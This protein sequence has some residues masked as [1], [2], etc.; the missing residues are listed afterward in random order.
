M[1]GPCAVQLEQGLPR[2]S[3]I[4]AM[5]SDGVNDA[6]E[7]KKAGIAIAMRIKGTEVTKEAAKIVLAEDIQV[8]LK[9]PSTD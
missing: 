5:I 4:V 6:P 8:Y 3:P 9:T 2:T 1:R 7:L